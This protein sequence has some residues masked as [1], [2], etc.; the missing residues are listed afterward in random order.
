MRYLSRLVLKHIYDKK[1]MSPSDVALM[2]RS[3]VFWTKK[4]A[5][6]DEETYSLQRIGWV[7]KKDSEGKLERRKELFLQHNIDYLKFHKM[8]QLTKEDMKPYVN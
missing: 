2:Q 6:S 5:P 8:P 4:I 3:I 1:N 7:L